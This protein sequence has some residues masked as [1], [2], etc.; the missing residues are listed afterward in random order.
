MTVRNRN[1]VSHAIVPSPNPTGNPMPRILSVSFDETLLTTRTMMLNSQGIE[2]EPVLGLSAAIHACITEDFDLAV[3]CH[4]IPDD[5]K[6]CIIK[7]VRAMS[8]M[9]VLTLR[10][11]HKPPLKTADYDIDSGDPQAFL[12]CVNRILKA[13]VNQ[14][15]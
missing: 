8:S 5:D 11:G 1:S 14:A 12:D 7:Q 10:Q 15:S 2:V 13:K 3:I 4:S 9:L 6:E